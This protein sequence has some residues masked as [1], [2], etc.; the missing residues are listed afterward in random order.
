M[1]YNTLPL[2]D[3]LLS[4]A[5]KVND[6]LIWTGQKCAGGY[7]RLR[8]NGKFQRAHRL[9]YALHHG[10]IAQGLIILHSC[11]NPACI[12]ITHLSAGTQL[13]NIQDMHAK[14]RAVFLSGETHPKAKLTSAQVAEIKQT[15]QPY[16]RTNGT[17]ALGKA[18]GVSGP[19]ISAIVLNKSWQ[20]AS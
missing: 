6:C 8:I 18:Y 10:E 12:E 4:K 5:T 3:K 17:K 20:N 9:I 15:Y 16:S 11:D 7:G 13:Q 1:A 19:T 14:R 2:I